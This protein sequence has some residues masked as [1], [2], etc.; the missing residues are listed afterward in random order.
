MNKQKKT[1][2]SLAAAMGALALA[3]SAHAAIIEVTDEKWTTTTQIRS[4]TN[5][6]YFGANTE[7]VAA[8]NFLNS[9][10]TLAGSSGGALAGGT[11]NGI[12]FYD[13]VGPTAVSDVSHASFATGITYD[14]SGF[15]AARNL[16]STSI[17]G[18][19]ATV[20]NNVGQSSI[21]QDIDPTPWT[22]DFHN[23]TPG[24]SVYVQVW[25]GV[26]TTGAGW[27]GT[28]NVEVNDGTT[29]VWDSQDDLAGEAYLYGFEA[30]ADGSG[31]LSLSFTKNTTSAGHMSFGGLIVQSAVPE[32]STTALLGLGGLT[33]ILRR[34]R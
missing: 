6:P 17:T 16:L 23:L 22:L 31:D 7:H 3:S 27:L 19:D 11:L 20:A 13:S 28:V 25:G 26:E 8:V 2:M 12:A 9:V 18:T 21:W 15:T 14:H 1:T 29:L 5:N 10:G 24:E 32:P 30:V 33:L 4:L 34:R